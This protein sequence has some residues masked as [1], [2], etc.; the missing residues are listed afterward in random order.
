[1]KPLCQSQWRTMAL[2]FLK[3]KSAR[4]E[5]WLGLFERGERLLFAHGCPRFSYVY[6]AFPLEHRQ[7]EIA[8]EGSTLRLF[9]TAVRSHLQGCSQGVL[10]CLTLGQ[11][12]DRAIRKAQA[13]DM[14]LAV[15]T[16]ALASAMTE[17]ACDEAE[18]EILSLDAFS[19][20]GATSRFSPG[21]GD[22]SLSHQ[23]EI[24]KVLDAGR[25]L[26]VSVSSGGLLLPRKTVTAVIGL[27]E[28]KESRE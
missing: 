13:E 1:M 26:G 20:C 6:R 23:E 4:E 24:L 2:G 25:R 5:D 28:K 7:D 16:D 17:C 11:G 15:V 22:L 14:A 12:A 9:G 3:M 10:L 18:E 27:K 19:S 8:W 21:Y